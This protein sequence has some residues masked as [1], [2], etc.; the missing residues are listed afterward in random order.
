VAI[1][2][3]L[4]YC[5]RGVEPK[6]LAGDLNKLSARRESIRSAGHICNKRIPPTGPPGSPYLSTYLTLFSSLSSIL[7]RPAMPAMPVVLDLDEPAPTM[8]ILLDL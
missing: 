8:P 1:P 5:R 3:A 6:K 2:V 4:K 7:S